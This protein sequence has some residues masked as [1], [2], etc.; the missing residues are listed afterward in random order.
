MPDTDLLS[1]LP[2]IETGVP[3]LDAALDGSFLAG[4]TCRAVGP[5]GSGRTTLG[6][7]VA[8]HHARGGGAVL[9]AT[10]LAES[11]ERMLRRLATFD[12]FDQRLVG[13]R[14]HYQNLLDTLDAEGV[15]GLLATVR[16]EIRAREATP[17]VVDGMS[18][19][20]EQTASPPDTRRLVSRLQRLV[21]VLKERQSATDPVIRG[22]VIGPEGIE[23]GEPFRGAAALLTG[24]AVPVSG[25]SRRRVRS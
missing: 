10:V 3:G 8:F 25:P 6:N 4:A 23:V 13:A 5:P 24:A 15:D 1:P 7:Q 9:F 16:R 22:F 18:P 11:H 21:S 17:L 14:H 20:E 12:L 19:I 2:R